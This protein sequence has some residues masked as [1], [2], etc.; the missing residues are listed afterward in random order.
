MQPHLHDSNRDPNSPPSE[1]ELHQLDPGSGVPVRVGMAVGAPSEMRAVA[2]SADLRRVNEIRG[3][4]EQV[5]KEFGRLDIL[6]NSAANF[7]PASIVSTTE[8]IWDASL[9]TNLKAIVSLYSLKL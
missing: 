4:F 1:D 2:L 5:A 3:L 6:V 7:L 8:E 9:N